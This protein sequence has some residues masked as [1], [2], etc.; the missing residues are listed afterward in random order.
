MR[1]FVYVL[2]LLSC[3]FCG[4]QVSLHVVEE[5]GSRANQINIV[6]LSEG[7][8]AASMPTFAGH[9]RDSMEY[10][11]S[12]E[13]WKQ[14]RN[15]CNVYRI[16]VASVDNGTDSG[17]AGGLKNTYFHS[18]FLEPSVPQLL[19]LNATGQSRVYTV[20]NTHVPEYDM[21]IVLVNDGKYGGSGGEISVSSVHANSRGIVEH[22]IGHSF[23]GLAD[24][25]DIDYAIYN[26]V[27]AP[28][29]TAVTNPAQ[30]KWRDWIVQGT[31]L[32]TAEVVGNSAVVGLYEGSMYRTK[33]WYRPHYNSLM[34]S[35]FRPVG[36]V[37]RQEFVLG[38]YRRVGMIESSAPVGSI[39]LVVGPQD[40]EFFVDTK[41]PSEGMPLEVK[42]RLD[43]VDLVGREGNV[44]RIASDFFGNG[45]HSITAVVRDG[46]PF[47]RTD[48]GG[49]LVEEKSWN[50]SLSGQLP[51]DLAGWRA[52]FG[53]DHAN[54]TG[55]GMVNMVKYA[56][57]LNPEQ[58]AQVQN[59]IRA[60][61]GSGGA[62]ALNSWG[63]MAGEEY[64]T[65]RV[66][67]RLRRSDV[68]YVVEVSGNLSDWR[69]G[70]GNTITLVDDE[71]ELV[72]RDVF[73]VSGGGT[74]Y[75]RL[76]VAAK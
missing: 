65:I 39:P 20:L 41:E 32:P 70:A 61:F 75:I 2:F 18:G 25:Y 74:R 1:G 3:A 73:P 29:N 6:Y 58:V 27:E 38:I 52:R 60:D 54:P 28:N 35:L 72:V 15:Y 49:L 7:Y 8:T 42:W 13:P 5:N 76:K 22:E 51:K 12:R 53:G 36:E 10:L 69:S 31:P 19:Y 9:V 14:Y 21:P 57:G 26:T 34:K 16:E 71:K 48:P 4:A 11:F 17:T 68:D 56:L 59:H 23:A 47:V 45:V 67:R 64:L 40:L 24:E 37:N 44:L 30:I 63:V 66:D 62:G 55:D 46:T 50:V 33:G 43:G